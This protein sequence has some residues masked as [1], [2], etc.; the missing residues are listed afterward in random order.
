M[1]GSAVVTGGASGLGRAAVEMLVERGFE[2]VVADLSPGP[3]PLPDGARFVRADVT[4]AEEV[5]AAVAAAT[6]SA[7]L[8]VAVACAG[9]AH[10]RRVL[11]SR[12]S[13]AIDEFDWVVRVNLTG[14]AALLVSAAEVMSATRRRVATAA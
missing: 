7:P 1:T 11:G 14:S 2:V 10:N 12:G 9:V 4:D 3:G 6:D 5:R 8:R 13:L